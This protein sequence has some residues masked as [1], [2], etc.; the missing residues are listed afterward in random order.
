MKPRRLDALHRDLAAGALV[1]FGALVALTVVVVARPFGSSG[2]VAVVDVSE[3][4]FAFAGATGC[5]VGAIR[6]QSRARR[7][8]ASLALACFVWGVGQTIWTVYEVWLGRETP[9]PSIADLGFLGFVPAAVVA[10]WLIPS[11]SGAGDN[12]RRLLDAMTVTCSVVLISWST[13]LG[14]AV[15]ADGVSWFAL[16]VSVAYPIGDILLLTVAV[17]AL[18]RG[19]RRRGQLTLISLGM[20]AM[21]LSDGA[22]AYL[23]SSGSFASVSIIDLGWCLGFA[24]IGLGGVV[25]N[26]QGQARQPVR[27]V[28]PASVLPYVGLVVAAVVV[29]SQN[30]AGRSVDRVSVALSTMVMVLVLS[31]Q[32]TTVHDNRVLTRTI[33][34]R[35]SELRH[36]AFYDALT[37]LANRELFINRVTHAL[38]LNARDQRPVSV[39]FLDLDGFKGINDTLGHAAGDE[40]LA[41]VADRLRGIVRSADTLARLGGDEFALLLEHG[42]EPET[43]ARAVVEALRLPFQLHGRLIRMSGSVG[44]S[45]MG[46]GGVK[47]SADDLLSRAD[48][49]MYAVKRSGRNDFRHYT[50]DLRLAE[51]DD[52]T[53]RQALADALQSG[54]VRAVFQPIYNLHTG[55]LA[56]YE[57]LAR[58]RHQGADVPPE[59]FVA[60][61]ERTGLIA[62]LTSVMLEHA[63]AQMARWS[64]ELGHSELVV[65]IN[66]SAQ[67]LG[68]PSLPKR[69]MAAVERHGL[70][71]DRLVLEITESALVADPLTARTL[72]RSMHQLG[73]TFSLDDFGSGFNGFSQLIRVPLRSV[74]LDQTFIADIDTDPASRE[75]LEGVML[76][77]RHLGLRVVGEGVERP[78][79]LKVL[80][81]VGCDAAQ[82]YLLGRPAPATDIDILGRLL[83]PGDD[84]TAASIPR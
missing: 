1:A 24:L 68:D 77:M 54:Q 56:A 18:A 65:G 79:Q 52:M 37:G 67:E 40:I 10:I 76:L 45:T 81:E 32:Y 21:A 58:W 60:V 47:I 16:A 41:L 36:Q 57:A 46:S 44:I 51:G 80:R 73:L 23:A 7:G 39:A 75:L 5:T 26:D 64:A 35:E 59:V 42:D 62:T 82:G 72:L 25:N 3:I 55:D 84:L 66:I 22:F 78:G 15:R 71:A 17:L 50:S 74:K 8:W 83:E 53:L 34:T 69:V 12:R 4:C 70:V 27:V 9:F 14:P 6:A 49:A 13:V 11:R 61:A 28:V 31:R 20:S 33:T 43:M 48:I 19:S 30:L 29:L 38:E 63:C 2:D